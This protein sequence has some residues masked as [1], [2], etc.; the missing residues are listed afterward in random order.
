MVREGTWWIAYCPVLD[1][2]SQGRTERSALRNLRDALL[3]F[4]EGCVQQG[5][6]GQVM[7]EASFSR[8]DVDGR[9]YWLGAPRQAKFN[10]QPVLNM[11]GFITGPEI[12]DRSSDRTTVRVPS[13][14]PWMI[15][16]DFHAQTHSR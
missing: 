1:V 13:V 2:A 3:L 5:T 6:W 14:P 10:S 16:A 7:R 12:A 15:R 11:S 8:I 9:N 4:I